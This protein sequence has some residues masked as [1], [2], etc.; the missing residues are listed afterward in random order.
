M[1]T[2]AH[3]CYVRTLSTCAMFGTSLGL[4]FADYKQNF[5]NLSAL[6]QRTTSTFAAATSIATATS[7]LMIKAD[8]LS[9][10]NI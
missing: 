1:S 6:F 10:R 8:E 2:H 5:T 4:S 7:A 9:N 3:R